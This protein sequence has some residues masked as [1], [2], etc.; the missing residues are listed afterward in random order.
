MGM[1]RD[2]DIIAWKDASIAP[3]GIKT[4]VRCFDNVRGEYTLPYPCRRTVYAWTFL[5]QR[6]RAAPSGQRVCRRRGKDMIW[7]PV[8]FGVVLGAFIAAII[9]AG[10]TPARDIDSDLDTDRHS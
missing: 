10:Y 3:L 8:V 1:K 6:G 2:S 5:T 9:L 7:M 4:E